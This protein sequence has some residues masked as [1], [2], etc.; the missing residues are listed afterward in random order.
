M[1]NVN[2]NYSLPVISAGY[3][4][5]QLKI[6]AEHVIN[7]IIENGNAIPAAEALSAM[8]AFVKEVK[9]SKQYI[10]FVREEIQKHGKVANTASGTKLEL[11]EV[12][13][14]YD[15]SNCNDQ[16][17]VDLE[18]QID[19]L[20]AQLSQRKDFLKTVTLSGLIVTNEDT[21]ETYKVYPPSK[22]S[23]SSYKVTIAK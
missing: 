1:S 2:L 23:T 14:K 13:T 10:D 22:T 7:D 3:T 12:G 18:M 6:A 4:K 20:E 15:F 16:L 8:E 17:L 11:S 5:T 21:G 9:S 19:A